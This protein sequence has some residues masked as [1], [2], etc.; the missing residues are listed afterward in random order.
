MSQNTDEGE[1]RT[2]WCRHSV[3]F[4]RLCDSDKIREVYVICTLFTFTLRGYPL[5]WL[6]T[7]PNKS[8]HSFGH[9]VIELVDAFHHFDHQAL[10]IEILKLQKAPDESVEK[11]HI[12]FLNLAFCFPEDEIDWEFLDGRFKY[13][14]HISE[15]LQILKLFEPLPAYLGVRFFKS[16]MDKVTVTSD[17]PSSSHQTALSPQCEVGE[18]ARTSVDLSH[19]PTPLG[20]N[21]C[22]DL[23]CKTICCHVDLFHQPLSLRS[24]DPLNCT[25]LCSPIPES[26]LVVHEDRVIDRVDIAQPTCVVIH[27]ECVRESEEELVGKDDL[28]LFVPHPLYLEISCDY[29]TFD[30]PCES[31]SLDVSTSDHS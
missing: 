12:R 10:N 25:V 7:L 30:F 19:P 29:A 3:V 28:L 15:N 13:L 6:I 27:H 21:I 5:Q 22:I 16:K 23:A 8:I 24:V 2:T 26:T 17:C 14:L 18:G 9:F 20:L 4:A 11:F 1:G 31:P